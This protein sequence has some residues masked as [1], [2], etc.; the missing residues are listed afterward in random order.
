M[1]KKRPD[2]VIVSSSSSR[3]QPRQQ[4][5][6]SVSRRGRS[7]S[8]KRTAPL[9]QQ[10]QERPQPTNTL[11]GAPEITRNVSL[12]DDDDDHDD[13]QDNASIPTEQLGRQGSSHMIRPRIVARMEQHQEQHGNGHAHGNT[14][15]EV[16]EMIRDH[17]GL[18]GI[19]MQEQSMLCRDESLLTGVA[20]DTAKS[21]KWSD[22]PYSIQLNHQ[23]LKRVPMSEVT[24]PGAI[25]GVDSWSTS[26]SEGEDEDDIHKKNDPHHDALLQNPACLTPNGAE[27]VDQVRRALEQ[28]EVKLT[29]AAASGQKISRETLAQALLQVADNLESAKDRLVMH[30]QVSRLI[31]NDEQQKNTKTNKNAAASPARRNGGRPQDPVARKH[32]H[33]HRRHNDNDDDYDDDETQEIGAHRGNKEARRRARSPESKG[34]S[35]VLNETGSTGSGTEFTDWVAELEDDESF[36][37]QPEMTF[38]TDLFG[39]FGGEDKKSRKDKKKSARARNNQDWDEAC[40]DGD[41]RTTGLERSNLEEEEEDDDEA[42]SEEEEDESHLIP[43]PRKKYAP[44]SPSRQAARGAPSSPS[45]QAARGQPPSPSRQAARGPSLV[46]DDSSNFELPAPAHALRARP[47]FGVRSTIQQSHVSN[48][49]H[50]QPASA[51]SKFAPKRTQTQMQPHK[52]A[53]P[54]RSVLRSLSP[55]SRPFA[56]KRAQTQ[57]QSHTPAQFSRSVIRSLSPITRSPQQDQD[58]DVLSLSSIESAQYQGRRTMHMSQPRVAPDD[59]AG[60]LTVLSTDDDDADSSN[61]GRQRRDFHFARQ[62]RQSAPMARQRS[63]SAHAPRQRSFQDGPP[64]RMLI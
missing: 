59:D 57:A 37:S 30:Q 48:A 34:E 31:A 13:D 50:K 32:A 40:A 64:L 55:V 27:S 61:L 58:D 12:L 38:F 41:S 60:M 45:R 56:P 52:P 51:A 1:S 14:R 35:N 11:G 3:Q 4:R 46:I 63:R 9:L 20:P 36:D 62:Q 7:K 15:N 54:S 33:H 29:S 21:I 44:S 18:S 24:T 10:Q 28:V 23:A 49:S 16:V 39:I 2:A 53:Q 8:K 19:P 5:P 43:A 22:T 25:R 42:F 6:T 26:G 47:L 17:T